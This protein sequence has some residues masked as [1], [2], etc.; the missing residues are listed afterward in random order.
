M[1]DPEEKATIL[2]V[3]DS[4]IIRTILSGIVKKLGQNIMVAS[5]GNTCIEIITTHQIDLLL[6]D[7]NMSGK[8]GMEVLSYLRDHHFTIPVI[9]ISGSND[10]EQAVECLKMGAYDFLIKPVNP[11]KL[12][13]T[14]KNVLAESELRKNFKLFSSAISQNPLSIVITDINGIVKYIN[15]AFTSVSGYTEKEVIGQTPRVLKSGKHSAAFYK[16]LWKTIRSGNIWKGEL[17]NKNK[18]GELYWELA[19]ISPI[20]GTNNKISHFISIKQDITENKKKLTELAASQ[21]RF[22]DLADL[23]P[24]TIFEMDIHGMI[25]FTNRMGFETFGYTKEDL[26][27]GVPCILL[28]APDDRAKVQFNMQQ[29]L[30]NIP[31]DNHEYTGLKKDGT[32]FPIL[33]YTSRIIENGKLVGIR[34]IV[35]DISERKEAEAKLQELNKTLE[36]R[37]EERT[38]DLAI[39][40]QQIIQQEKLAS[41]GQLAA[42]IAH[43]INNPLNF[44]KINFATQQE[45]ISDLLAILNE[46]RTFIQQIDKENLFTAELLNL[47]QLEHDLDLNTLLADLPKIF[48]ESQRGFERITTIINSMRNFAYKHAFEEKVLFDI[49]KGI[50]DTLIIARNEY[51]Y[52]ADIE[53]NL[54]ELPLVPC[55][56]EQLNQVILNLIINSAHAIVSEMKTSNGKIVINTWKESNFVYCSIADDGPGIPPEV[57][58]HIFE[59][60]FTTKKPGHGT[61]LGLSISYDIIVNK[62]DG[63]LSVHCPKEGGTVFTIMLPIKHNQVKNNHDKR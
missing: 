24:Q 34:G 18:N 13:V 54:K 48:S 25:S 30:K 44:I 40:Q 17:I 15:P 46:Y 21:M 35:L 47:K 61:G 58:E 27:K 57:Q 50:R 36:Q 20:T 5:D 63:R 1:H 31:F 4:K 19:T 22:H 38:K 56:P 42:G 14:I 8:N 60:F 11:D 37:V 6:L 2:V 28:F 51:R 52:C 55:N 59:P 33:V 26:Q 62:H 3:D 32:S 7:I 43:E 53:T 10:I 39:S 41:I 23:L 16:N 45:N 12:A 9:M 29:R 49:N